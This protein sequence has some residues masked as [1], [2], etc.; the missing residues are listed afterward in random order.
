MDPEL[1]SSIDQHSLR[2]ISASTAAS[3]YISELASM[4]K[5]LYAGP[6]IIE[7][8]ASR[9]KDVSSLY[10]VGSIDAVVESTKYFKKLLGMP[11][12][13]SLAL[14]WFNEQPDSDL[15]QP[16]VEI[17]DLA[18]R[19]ALDKQLPVFENRYASIFEPSRVYEN[20]S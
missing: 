6:G 8:H 4:T 13:N 7:H 16:N 9:V 1:H 10:A 15:L 2:E 20:G 12:K 11:D 18:V 17:K 5:E 19:L 3:D 14:I